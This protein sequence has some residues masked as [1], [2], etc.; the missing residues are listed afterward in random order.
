MTSKWEKLPVVSHAALPILLYRFLTTTDSYELYITDLIHLWSEKLSR[1]DI[2]HRANVEE[3]SIDPGEDTDQYKVFLDKLQE[4]FTGSKNSEVSLKSGVG[5][6]F[7]NLEIITTTDLP[8][9]LDPLTWIFYVNQGSAR[10][11]A[12]QLTIP[13]LQ[14]Q[15]ERDGLEKAL[16]KTLKEKDWI[17]GKIFDKIESL[18]LDLSAVFPGMVGLRSSD[19]GISRNRAAKYIPG[20][21][22][23]DESAWRRGIDTKSTALE[24]TRRLIDGVSDQSSSQIGLEK[25][26]P[27]D[28]EWWK[29]VNAD[30]GERA[31]RPQRRVSRSPVVSASHKSFVSDEKSSDD[32]EFQVRLSK[33][34]LI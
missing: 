32:D 4:A 7:N 26:V 17:L 34:S 33:Y 23:F 29:K 1:R 28:E 18:G 2:I 10:E 31:A 5:K 6:K 8:A 3:T 19:G 9:P 24:L 21:T 30:E 15:S 27:R 12:T 22:A 14:A 25:M 20:L 16:L 13:L 11:L